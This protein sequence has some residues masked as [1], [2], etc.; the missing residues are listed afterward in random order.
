MDALDQNNNPPEVWRTVTNAI[1]ERTAT[2]LDGLL[3][4]MAAHI[5]HDLPLALTDAGLKN[6]SGHSHVRDFHLVNDVLQ[7]AIDGLQDSVSERYNP[8]L[9]WLDRF[10]K[11]HDETL[12]NFGIRL[13]RGLAWYNAERLQNPNRKSEVLESIIRSTNA[14]IRNLRN[15]PSRILRLFLRLSGLLI[16]NFRRWPPGG[17][18]R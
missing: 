15:P 18:A 1:S 14:I 6:S 12:T 4:S 17:Q 10:S 5:I 9:G 7:E 3:I 13:G 11:R 2:V 16:Q 8:F